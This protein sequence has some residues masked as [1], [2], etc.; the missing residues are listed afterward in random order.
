MTAPRTQNG[1]S[2][3]EGVTIF[4]RDDEV[5]IE[6]RDGAGKIFALAGLTLEAA[7]QFNERLTDACVEGLSHRRKAKAAA[8]PK[9]GAVH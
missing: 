1:V 6:F 7:T 3:A 5:F 2:L 8:D 9:R 4:V